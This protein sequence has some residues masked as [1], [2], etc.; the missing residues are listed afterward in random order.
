LCDAFETARCGVVRSV[1]G[2]DDYLKETSSIRNVVD[3][4]KSV[5]QRNCSRIVCHL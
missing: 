2:S 1:F 4:E 3:N 5:V